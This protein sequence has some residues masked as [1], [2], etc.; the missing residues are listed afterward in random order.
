MRFLR[1]LPL[2]V[3]LPLLHGCGDPFA[4]CTDIGCSHGVTFELGESINVFSVE[5]PVEVQVCIDANCFEDTV[6]LQSDGSF[7]AGTRAGYTVY[8]ADRTLTYDADFD[9]GEGSHDVSIRISRDGAVVLQKSR[10]DVA[11]TESRPNGP[12][13]EPLCRQT[14]VTL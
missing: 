4:T 1:A 3:L 11:F 9:P 13:C 12:T 7:G 2:L 10:E 6:R 8:V 14:R 5:D